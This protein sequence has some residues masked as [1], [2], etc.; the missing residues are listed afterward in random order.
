MCV[1]NPNGSITT[2]LDKDVIEK[3]TK[4]KQLSVRNITRRT[5]E[6]ILKYIKKG[7]TFPAPTL[8]EYFPDFLKPPTE[9]QVKKMKKK[10][11]HWKI[12]YNW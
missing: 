8:L 6:R 11:K 1:L 2:A 12:P 7:F 4:Y 5:D 10:C 9:E 3:V